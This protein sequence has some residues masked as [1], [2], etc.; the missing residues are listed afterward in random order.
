MDNEQLNNRLTNIETSFFGL[1]KRLEKNCS[2]ID[3]IHVFIIGDL[4]N[5]GVRTVI[6][7][8][9]KADKERKVIGRTI[10]FTVLT[11]AIKAIWDSIIG[12]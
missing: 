9:K 12:K 4:E 3:A 7:D 10:N 11:L 1:E 5:E 6:N 2:K 8:L